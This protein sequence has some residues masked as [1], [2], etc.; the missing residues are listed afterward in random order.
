[1]KDV[2][3]IF[4][5]GGPLFSYTIIFLM[6]V[7]IGLFV[8]ASLEKDY[9]KKSRSILAS[10]GWLALAWGYLGRT[11]GLIMAFDNIAAAGEIA[12]EHLAGG[13]KMAIVGPLLGIVAFLLARIGILILQMKNKKESFE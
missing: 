9:S 13:I 2:F 8:K 11:F 1:M 3:R 5:D 12:P 4:N 10:V 7:I 6:L